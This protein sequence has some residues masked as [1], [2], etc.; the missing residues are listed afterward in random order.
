M[1]AVTLGKKRS[2]TDILANER[3]KSRWNYRIL[4]SF[5]VLVFCFFQRT[6]SIFMHAGYPGNRSA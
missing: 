6:N 4:Y 3:L 2:L 5:S 1:D